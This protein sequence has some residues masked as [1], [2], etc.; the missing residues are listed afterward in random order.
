MLRIAKLTAVL[1]I[2]VAFCLVGTPSRAGDK[3]Y[4]GGGVGLGFGD[5]NFV[6]LSGVFA[7]NVVPRVTTGL[8]LT[9]RSRDDGRFEERITTNDY[10]AA[11]FARFFVKRP[12]FLH[13]EYERMSFEYIRSDLSTSRDEFDSFLVGGGAAHPLSAHATLFVSALY[14]LAYDSD[15]FRQPYTSP[16]I[17]RA[18]VGFTF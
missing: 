2:V 15:E 12:F 17:V 11:I 10:G 1:L 18:G 9:W 4:A 7:Y 13:A 8:R 3:F 5:V 6:D 14:N 16:W